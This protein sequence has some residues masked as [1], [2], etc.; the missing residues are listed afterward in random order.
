MR[1]FPLFLLTFL[2]AAGLIAGTGEGMRE[3]VLLTFDQPWRVD[4]SGQPAPT[5]WTEP[6]FDDSAWTLTD[7]FVS[8]L[9]EED[10][11]I[12]IARG[13]DLAPGT[14][15]AYLRTT[16]DLAALPIGQ[17]R[18]TLD[19]V[20]KDG[21]VF[22]L[23]GKEIGRTATMPEG[24]ITHET[25]ARRSPRTRLK[26]GFHLD[27]SRLVV[28]SNVL[29]VSLHGYTDEEFPP[30]RVLALELTLFE[31]LEARPAT[32]APRHVRVL[33]L[34]D[35]TSQAVVSW[36]TDLPVENSRLHYD[37]EPRRGRLDRYRH[38][39]DLAHTGPITLTRADLRHGMAP[40]TFAHVH[41]TGLTPDTT[42][43]FTVESGEERSPEFHFRTAPAV[44]QPTKIL[45][46]GD[47]R[48]NGHEPYFHHDRRSMNRRMA[49]LTEEHPDILAFLHGGDFAQLAQW[50]FLDAWLTDHELTRTQDGR[51]IP[52]IPVR[53]NHDR[54]IGFEEIFWWPQE[55]PDYYYS[56]QLTPRIGV[57]VLNTEM[58]LGGRQRQWLA[59]TLATLRPT[60][61]WLLTAYHR[62][63]W[64][65]VRGFEDGANRRRFWVP[66]FEEFG[67]D[68][69]LESHD[70][71]MKR[72]VPIRDAAEHPEGV[73]YIGDGG[74]GVPQRQPDT[75]RWYLQG[76]GL[77]RPVHHVHI[78]EFHPD[79]L[80]GIAF[81]MGGTIIDDF[82]RPLR[83]GWAW[84]PPLVSSPSAELVDVPVR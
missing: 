73:V 44:D 81:D 57:V 79:H 67:V 50:R 78:L 17:I 5:G 75:T 54:D 38:T 13:H 80:R 47:S 74:L 39:A 55:T 77:A 27:P 41:L 71:A 37:T 1:A 3:T 22:Y 52:L 8:S 45:F 66:L 28:G 69:S 10:L 68:L 46:G 20:A 12:E 35:P 53:G 58:S 9:L 2:S 19:M 40:A 48:I 56:L 14:D 72:T 7:G 21:A 18:L 51:I 82:S 26:S 34:E 4:D 6:G 59:D 65:S 29:A 84:E 42:Y 31:N 61:R 83:T 63:S 76:E 16:F 30:E 43:Y 15:T 62:P 70:H 23:N 64:P 49:A 33:W 60:N 25:L 11:R 36:T 24:E 32:T